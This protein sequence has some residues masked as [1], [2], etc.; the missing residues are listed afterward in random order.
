MLL[1]LAKAGQRMKLSS[2]DWALGVQAIHALHDYIGRS[3]QTATEDTSSSGPTTG[4]TRS[5]ADDGMHYDQHETKGRSI[6]ATGMGL[7]RS[8]PA[9]SWFLQSSVII[10]QKASEQA[11]EQ[12]NER[13]VPF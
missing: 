10:A 6:E 1:G 11:S 7:A 3:L 12:A 9:A 5:L 4:V 13:T 8:E 2:D